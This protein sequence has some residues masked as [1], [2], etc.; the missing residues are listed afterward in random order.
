MV[1]FLVIAGIAGSVVGTVVGGISL[2]SR[3]VEAKLRYEDQNIKLDRPIL[4]PRTRRGSNLS[5]NHAA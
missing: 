2:G 4:A 5:E 3:Y 1:E